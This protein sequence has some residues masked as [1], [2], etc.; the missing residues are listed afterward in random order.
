[1]ATDRHI[2]TLES[3]TLHS[4]DLTRA[5][6]GDF[7]L[8]L[9][10]RQLDYLLGLE[11]GMN[12]DDHHWVWQSHV[13]WAAMLGCSARQAKRLIAKARQLDLIETRQ[14]FDNRRLY[15]VRYKQLAALF[16]AAEVDMPA[17][18]ASGLEKSGEPGEQWNLWVHHDV[19]EAIAAADPEPSDSTRRVESPRITRQTESGPSKR[20]RARGETESGLSGET[21]S[22]LSGETESGLSYKGTKTTHIDYESEITKLASCEPEPEGEA[23]EDSDAARLDILDRTDAFCA[24]FEERYERWRGEPLDWGAPEWRRVCNLLDTWAREHPGLS[25]HP[26]WAGVIYGRIGSRH[27][28]SPIGLVY[29]L[30]LE[31][32]QEDGRRW[33]AE[34]PSGSGLR[35]AGMATRY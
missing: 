26:S 30:T 27:K 32:F 3:P 24:D 34:A 11:G 33:H 10:I 4:P 19:V 1:M 35:P 5:L 21:E 15:R 23:G 7:G 9:F 29:T 28:R 16:E 25:I 18:A 2:P 12:R 20:A 8:S 14:L 31:C 22:G 6:N 17:W 13:D